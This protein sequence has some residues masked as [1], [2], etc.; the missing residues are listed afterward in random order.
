[1]SNYGLLPYGPYI[2]TMQTVRKLYQYPN[3]F[4]FNNA[5]GAIT[6][7]IS[8]FNE[9]AEKL[10][11][12][13]KPFEELL[14]QYGDTYQYITVNGD[15]Y[16]IYFTSGFD[17]GRDQDYKVRGYV[18]ED[19]TYAVYFQTVS[20]PYSPDVVFKDRHYSEEDMII[21]EY[22]YIL[23]WESGR[24]NWSTYWKMNV[25]YDGTYVKIISSDAVESIPALSDMITPVATVTPSPKPTETEPAMKVEGDSAFPTSTVVKVENISESEIFDEAQSVLED[26]RESVTPSFE[27]VKTEPAIKYEIPTGIKV[28]G[29]AAF[30]TNTIV[31]AESVSEGEIFERA[32]SVLKDIVDKMAVFEFGATAND[33][34]VQPNGKVKVI[35]NIPETLSADNLKM[36]HILNDEN[37][38]EI[39][40]S[41][42]TDNKTVTAE[43]EH[44]GTC[45]L[46]NV[47]I[48]QADDELKDI[49]V[50]DTSNIVVLVILVIV[51]ASALAVFVIKRKRE[52]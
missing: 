5:T 28:E 11:C 2:V 22:G 36:F 20:L 4:E 44:L 26:S 27:S 30:P 48:E 9:L 40:I 43:L 50:N 49:Q 29:D 31:K 52:H 3:K 39:G 15:E 46:A 8:Y 41:V 18:K 45:V 42:D 13:D 14:A 10:F 16:V 32:Q 37:T 19:D 24:G 33:E 38:E 6:V 34:A 23:L 35:F 25:S 47:K 1:M 7:K 17:H 21:D 12:L 51:F